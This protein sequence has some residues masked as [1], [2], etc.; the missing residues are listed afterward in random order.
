MQP[1]MKF[2]AKHC[3]TGFA[4]AGAFTAAI[5]WFNVGNLWHLVSTSDIGLMAIIVFWMLN[6][7]VFAG[8]QTAI[9]VMM[10]QEKDET[11]R[12]GTPVPVRVAAKRRV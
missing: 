4:I 3:L 1:V 8:V 5:L 2:Y 7:I 9:A 10:M 12:G 6:G 11:P